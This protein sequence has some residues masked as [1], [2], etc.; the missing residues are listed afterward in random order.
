LVGNLW[1][2]LQAVDGALQPGLPGKV[3]DGEVPS[4]GRGVYYTLVDRLTPPG[5]PKGVGEHYRSWHFRQLTDE[6]YYRGEHDG[7]PRGSRWVFVRE[8]LV[9]AEMDASTVVEVPMVSGGKDVK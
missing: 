4:L 8:A 2:Y 9:G 7:E 3:Q 5:A 6:R 1:I